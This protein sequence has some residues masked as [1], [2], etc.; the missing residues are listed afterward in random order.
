MQFQAAR[1]R[2]FGI[3]RAVGGSTGVL[4]G[5]VLGET[6]IMAIAA[7]VS[8]TALGLQLAW[9]GVELYRDFAGLRLAWVVPYAPLAAGAAIVVAV[10]LLAATP[11][12]IRLA[13]KPARA[14]LASA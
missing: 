5:L 2:E 10:A 7:L 8:G 4:V 13:R 6:I 12:V 1:T 3:L 9:M 14:L 11:A